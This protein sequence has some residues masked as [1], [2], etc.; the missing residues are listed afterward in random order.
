MQ[1]AALAVEAA[2]RVLRADAVPAQLLLPVEIVDR[3]NCEAWDRPYEARPLP[4][5]HRFVEA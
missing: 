5:W 2:V 4:E 3:A 1:L